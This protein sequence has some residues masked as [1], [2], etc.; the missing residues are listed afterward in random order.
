MISNP[1]YPLGTSQDLPEDICVNFSKWFFGNRK[2]LKRKT[3]DYS[4]IHQNSA[5]DLCN[6]LT[7]DLDNNEIIPLSRLTRINFNI[8]EQTKQKRVVMKKT[9]N[10]NQLNKLNQTRE[11]TT[12]SLILQS[13][14]IEIDRRPLIKR[15]NKVI[16][17]NKSNHII[18][19]SEDCDD[20]EEEIIE[21]D[22]DN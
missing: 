16:N 4:Q 10:Q 18:H 12:V 7:R 21:I 19:P 2:Q 20:T 14:S 5:P 3:A 6:Y 11:I 15:R 17:N 22:C 1:E 13:E 8:D 9:N